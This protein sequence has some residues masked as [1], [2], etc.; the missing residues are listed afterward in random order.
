MNNNIKEEEEKGFKNLFYV[1]TRL[2]VKRKSK[3]KGNETFGNMIK[4]KVNN[5]KGREK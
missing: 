3:R 4:N 2:K 5:R 1:R